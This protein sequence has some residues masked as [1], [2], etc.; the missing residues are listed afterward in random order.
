MLCASDALEAGRA[1]S[2]CALAIHTHALDP[3]ASRGCCAQVMFKKSST[4]K[5]ERQFA[6]HEFVLSSV[7]REETP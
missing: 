6:E 1:S 4:K 3:H 5:Y 7:A 2:H